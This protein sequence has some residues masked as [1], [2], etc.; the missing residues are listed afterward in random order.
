MLRELKTNDIAVKN[1]EQLKWAPASRRYAL[2][3]KVGVDDAAEEDD[4]IADDV[5][6]TNEKVNAPRI[7]SKHN[8]VTIAVYGQICMAAKSYQSAICAFR[9]SIA[10]HFR[11]YSKFAVYLLHA[12]D[13]F[14]DDPVICLSLAIASVGRAMQ[15]QADNR[16]HLIAQVRC[17]LFSQSS[18]CDIRFLQGMAFLS[19]YRTLRKSTP[20]G[21][22]EIEFNFGRIFHQLGKR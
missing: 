2:S 9:P 10:L 6:P 17:F 4:D 3:T 5:D 13:Y 14:P 11:W 15:R 19:R 22:G 1:P 16:H 12:F 21:L 20:G 8:P 7:L 18:I